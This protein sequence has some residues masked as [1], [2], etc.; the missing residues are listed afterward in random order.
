[1]KAYLSKEPVWHDKTDAILAL[2]GR[3]IRVKYRDGMERETKILI[4]LCPTSDRKV[5]VT[6]WMLAEPSDRSFRSTVEPE[7]EDM[8]QGT[9]FLTTAALQ[10]LPN[11]VSAD[12]TAQLSLDL[13]N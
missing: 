13:S 6:L 10:L 4:Q 1:M 3:P 11:A 5:G 9:L 7:Y 8:P 12:P 2:S